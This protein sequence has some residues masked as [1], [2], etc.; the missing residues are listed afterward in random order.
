M[1]KVRVEHQSNVTE[2]GAHY[3]IVGDHQVVN[4]FKKSDEGEVPVQY[5]AINFEALT[6]YLVHHMAQFENGGGTLNIDGFVLP[7]KTAARIYVDAFCTILGNCGVSTN[8][9]KIR[10]EMCP[11]CHKTGAA[12]AQ[13]FQSNGPAITIPGIIH[14]TP[15]ESPATIVGDQSHAENAAVNTSAEP[16]PADVQPTPGETQPGTGEPPASGEAPQ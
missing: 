15:A 6:E 11:A 10:D 14:P 7:R 3:V 2:F 1:S 8:L 16:V 12:P 5:V 4:G 9:P 13:E